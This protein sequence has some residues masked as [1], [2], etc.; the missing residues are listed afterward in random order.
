MPK[1]SVI[2]PVYNSQNSLRKCLDSL[3]N[4]KLQDIEIICV[5][6]GSTDNSLKILEE[7]AQKDFRIR[8]LNQKNSG[9]GTA[10]N[11]GIKNARG[12]YISFV[13]S[14]DFVSPAIYIFT[15][16]M[17]EKFDADCIQYDYKILDEYQK[18]IKKVYQKNEYL[19]RNIILPQKCVCDYKDL[20]NT[21]M[22]FDAA[23]W[24]RIY[25]RQFLLENDIWFDEFKPC[26]EDAGFS[27][28]VRIL[29]RICYVNKILYNYTMRTDSISHN[30]KY[31]L[32]LKEILNSFKKRIQKHNMF[33]NLYP[34][35]SAGVLHWCYFAYKNKNPNINDGTFIQNLKKLIDDNL[36]SEGLLRELEYKIIS[37]RVRR[38]IK[39]DLLKE[40]KITPKKILKTIFSVEDEFG[41]ISKHKVI[42]II[43]IKM[44]FKK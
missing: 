24:K 9:A 8:I 14:D 6:D 41:G 44:K 33:P 16:P 5:N 11:M 7:Y 22:T 26:G 13:D 30:S 34:Q 29:G 40:F 28:E 31:I 20:G 17:A 23:P 3:L 2:V 43:G 10:R 27:L 18:L 38:E 21:L 12:Q 35:Y 25:R 1:V 4:Q 15:I 37:E 19:K 36:I 39:Q 32:P 42:T